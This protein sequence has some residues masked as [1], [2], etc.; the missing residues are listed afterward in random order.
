MAQMAATVKKNAENARQAS[1]LTC[2]TSEVA[3]RGG[4]VV[5]NAVSAMSR[6]EESSGKISQ[7]INVIDEIAR[8]TNLL[9]INAAVEAARAGDAGLG[10]AVVAGEVRNLAQRSLGAARDIKSLIVNSSGQVHEGVELVNQAGTS[11]GEIVEAIKSVSSIVSDIARASAEQA[12]G[13]DQVNRTLT[14]MDEATQQNS[15]LGQENANTSTTLEAQSAVMTK[16][17][18]FF[19]LA[20]GAA[21]DA[22]PSARRA[23][24]WA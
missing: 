15:A 10:F 13:I 9:A 6:I 23:S 20:G 21:R 18:A 14:Q 11:L 12:I 7:I 22:N 5:T 3:E 24:G 8:Q 1:E 19:R 4:R 16:H 17:V 2:V